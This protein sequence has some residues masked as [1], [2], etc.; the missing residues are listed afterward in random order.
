M[1]SFPAAMGM[2]AVGLVVS[3]AIKAQCVFNP[4]ADALQYRRLCY[5]DIQPLFIFRGVA[6]GLLPYVDAQY[7]YPVLTGLFMDLAGRV[8]RG[9]AMVS[10]IANSNENYFQVTVL[11]LAPFAFFVTASLRPRVTSRRLLMWSIGSPLVLYA[12]HNWD[13]I[14]VALAAV[15]IAGIEDRRDDLGSSALAAGASAKLYPLFLLPGVLL[16]RW[17]RGDRSSA[18]R[19]MTGFVAV[20]VLLNLPWVV[21]SSGVGPVFDRPEIVSLAQQLELRDPE[22]NGWMGIWNFHAARYPDFGTVWFWI[23]HH[24]KAV[25]PSEFWR[26]PIEGQSSGYKDFV[27]ITSLLLFAGGSLWMLWAGWRRQKTEAEF[28]LI[29]VSLGILAIFLLVSK[30]HSPQYALWLVPLLAMLNIPWRYVVAYFVADLG[31][32][33]SGFYY[34]TVMEFADPA[35]KGMFEVAVLTRALALGLLVWRSTSAQRLFPTPAK[36]AH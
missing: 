5:N 19:I 35:W 31:V 36:A 3:Y 13:L 27:S 12:F 29:S 24:L 14:A 20:F 6:N 21:L 11:M 22:S 7:E 2:T 10:D 1:A 16:E 4:W 17:S 34:F 28:P 8:L 9:L 32:F 23:A 30:V 26:V 18:V 25:F 15:A 33:V